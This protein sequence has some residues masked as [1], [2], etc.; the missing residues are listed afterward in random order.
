MLGELEP[1]TVDVSDGLGQHGLGLAA[2]EDRDVMPLPQP[3]GRATGGPTNRVP[4]MMST[5]TGAR[6]SAVRAAFFPSDFIISTI[7][8]GDNRYSLAPRLSP[9]YSRR[10]AL[11]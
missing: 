10:N 1:V 8:L 3:V 7:T 11:S 5:R 2:M 6:S 9:G 4:P